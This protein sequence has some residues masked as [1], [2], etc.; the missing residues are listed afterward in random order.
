[1]IQI[2]TILKLGLAECIH[3][4]NNERFIDIRIYESAIVDFK[5]WPHIM[6]EFD[7]TLGK[8][9]FLYDVASCDILENKKRRDKR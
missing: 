4:E 1:M 8:S 3:T 5:R 7:K 9:S 2:E 6:N